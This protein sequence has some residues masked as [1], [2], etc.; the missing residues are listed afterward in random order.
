M[1]TPPASPSSDPRRATNPGQRL[2]R[3]LRLAQPARFQH[4]LE[5][6]LRAGDQRLSIWACANDLPCTRL[7][8]MVARRCGGAVQRNRLKRVIRAAFRLCKHELPSGLDLL[9]APRPGARLQLRDALDALRS[10]V[11]RLSP[12]LRAR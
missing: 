4:I 5:H 8:L 10:L 3:R 6:G 2:P 12:R 11:A 7:G 1:G 9:V